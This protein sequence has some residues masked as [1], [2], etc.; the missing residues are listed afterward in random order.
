MNTYDKFLQAV[1]ELLFTGGRAGN[2]AC[3]SSIEA[4][5]AAVSDWHIG[6]GHDIPP[7]WSDG[8]YRAILDGLKKGRDVRTLPFFRLGKGKRF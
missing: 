4:F 2:I 3:A 6:N 5:T 8:S 1:N 7:L